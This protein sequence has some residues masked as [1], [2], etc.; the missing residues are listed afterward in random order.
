[1]ANFFL[2]KGLGEVDA[3]SERANKNLIR[4]S[5]FFTMVVMALVLFHWGEMRTHLSYLKEILEKHFR[6]IQTAMDG[7]CRVDETGKILEVNHSLCNMTGYE[8]RELASMNIANLDA[9][10]TADEIKELMEAIVQKGHGRFESVQ[11]RKDGTVFDIEVS[12]QIYQEAEKIEFIAFSRDI[13]ERK[14]SEKKLK[15]SET[16]KNA[17]LEA[18]PIPVFY[19]DHHGRYLGFNKA[20]EQFYGKRKEQMVGKSVF[21]L[22]P[23]EL[24]EIY[25]AKDNELLCNGGTQVYETQVRD[26][27]GDIR[28]VIFYKAIFTTDTGQIGG[29]IG[30]I[31][32]ISERKKA[33]EK[34]RESEAKF[35]TLF[36]V[37]AIPLCLVNS[38]GDIKFINKKFRQVFGYTRNDIPSIEQWWHLAYPDPDYRRWVMET[39]DQAVKNSQEGRFEIEPIE[40]RVTCKNQDVRQVIISGNTIKDGFL[41]TFI[42]ITQIKDAEEALVNSISLLDAALEST[43]DGILV[44][45]CD[46]TKITRFNHKFADLWQVPEDI[47]SSGD[48]SLLLAYVGSRVKDTG[49]FIEKA[50]EMYHQPEKEGFDLLA[51]KDGRILER[52]SIPQRIGDRI[53][54]RVWSI[55]D[56]TDRFY[57]EVEL[58]KLSRAIDASPAS[59]VITDCDGNIEYINPKF[60]EVSGYTMDDV[61]GQNSRTLSS[62]RH[63]PEFFKELWNTITAGRQWQGEFQNRNK[64]GQIYWE[65]AS[66]SPVMNPHGKITHYVAVK[67]EITDRKKQEDALW[68]RQRNAALEADI[69]LFLTRRIKLSNALQHC[70]QSLV[71]HLDVAFAR[72]WILNPDAQV[73]ELYAS[74]GMYTHLDGKHSRVPVGSYKIGQIASEKKPHFSNQVIGDPWIHDQE[75]ARREGMVAFAGYPLIAEGQPIGVLGLF[76]RSPLDPETL[77]TLGNLSRVLALFIMRQDAEKDL[78]ESE[79]KFRSLYEATGDAVILMDQNR[80]I[81]CNPAALKM[82]GCNSLA[83]CLQLN[84][85]V[86]SPQ[87]QPD[88][89]NSLERINELT[90]TAFKEKSCRFEW[91]FKRRDGVTFPADILLNRIELHGQPV[92]E[93]VVRDITRQKQVELQLLSAKEAAETAVRVKS[94]F[95][96]NMSHEIRTPLNLILGFLE[97][98]L[99]EPL[100]KQQQRAHLTTAR[101]AGVSLLEVINDILDISK[102]ENGLLTIEQHPLRISRLMHDVQSALNIAAKEKGLYLELDIHPAVAGVFLG[103]PLRLKQILMNLA[104]NAVKF[105]GKGG[106]ILRVMPAESEYKLHFEVED[107]GIGIPA[108]RLRR[109]F[110]PFTQA[111]ASTTRRYGGTGLGTTIA[112]ELVELMGGDIW[113]QSREG[114]GS[115]FH[116]TVQLRP[117]DQVPDDDSSD[118]LPTPVWAGTRKGFRILLVED[119][120]ANVNLARIRLEQK[121]HEVTVAWNGRD[122]VDFVQ[123]ADFDIILMD[124]QMPVMGGVEAARRIRRL[125]NSTKRRVPIIAMTAAVMQEEA[126]KYLEAGM[127]AVVAKPINFSKLFKTIESLVPEGVGTRIESPGPAGSAALESKLPFLDGIDV[128]QAIQRW[129]NRENFVSGLRLFLLDYSTADVQ[130]KRYINE[131]DLDSAYRMAHKLRGVAGNLSLSEVTDTITVVDSALSKEQVDKAQAALLPFSQALAKTVASIRQLAVIKEQEEAPEREMDAGRVAKVFAD[132]MAAFD[133]CKPSIVEPYL[134]ELETYFSKEALSPIVDRLKTF[135]FDGAKQETARF[136]QILKTKLER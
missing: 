45:S 79:V 18:I 15:E 23:P 35:R 98:V 55:R 61:R 22:N 123:S 113:A 12:V 71:R 74:S 109:I 120:Q 135:D 125:E 67:E 126:R 116:F 100:M 6:V 1:M 52:Y 7:F 84:I 69:G 133:L 24:A 5:A 39:W 11:R 80:F 132:L 14:L 88:G 128:D 87:C 108:D 105:T 89:H 10:M 4:I 76:S 106:V 86:L 32:D 90:V 104:G 118:V 8:A 77:D 70:T 99:E 93:A 51:L 65:L 19:K 130:L 26:A 112:R 58:K 129:K 136:A 40:Y 75:W 42:D 2:F 36:D 85:V 94:N 30:A 110:D 78:L 37:A 38:A 21:D 72:V 9:K 115:T 81:D 20:Y 91:L 41:A 64:D 66:I 16:F 102:L 62:G 131:R 117:T 101:K 111:D 103:D 83:D 97:L 34:L 3:M 54:G 33:E 82:F 63:A 56:I 31:Q 122:A 44:V 46:G 92:L 107:T 124:I 29:L 127:D 53:V 57:A 13:T 68:R 59:V 121:A 28:D 96:A 73:L 49:A 60:T 27:H 119:V 47:L 114:K 25:H 50:K 43:A 48:N 17:L 95:L 134:V